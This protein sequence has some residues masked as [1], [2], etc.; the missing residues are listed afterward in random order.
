MQGV[1]RFGVRSRRVPRSAEI[2]E[3]SHNALTL[4]YLDGGHGK[5]CNEVDDAL[6][7]AV[8]FINF[9]FYG[10]CSV[11]RHGRRR[12]ITTSPVGKRPYLFFKARR[13]CSARWAVS[14]RLSARPGYCGSICGGRR[15]M[16]MRARTP[17]DRGFILLL[18]LTSLTGLALLAG[19]YYQRNGAYCWRSIRR[20]DGALLFTPSLRKIRPRY[21]SKAW[22]YSMGS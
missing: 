22:P 17:C 4:K 7:C 18:L 6:R 2:A 13:S 12:A 20:G 3:A 21:F 14:V 11:C 5:G 1:I 9:T 15:Y 8:A 19:V 16:A 10:L